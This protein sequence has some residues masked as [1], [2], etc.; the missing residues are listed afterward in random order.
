MPRRHLVL[1]DW[2]VPQ[3]AGTHILGA[4]ASQFVRWQHC[5]RHTK[6][7]P[8]LLP[9]CL[10]S[11]QRDP[12]RKH[13]LHITTRSSQLEPATSWLHANPVADFFSGFPCFLPC[14]LRPNFQFSLDFYM[15][16][17]LWTEPTSSEGRATQLRRLVSCFPP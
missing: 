10:S 9:A 2:G 14:T 5:L 6:N 17:R 7:V 4:G 8:P 3:G 12:S 1:L 15:T 16:L 13:S 11:N